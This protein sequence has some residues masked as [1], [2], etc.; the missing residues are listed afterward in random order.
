MVQEGSTAC[1]KALRNEDS[2]GLMRWFGWDVVWVGL[3]W[4]GNVEG[5]TSRGVTILECA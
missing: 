3:F 2:A 4:T 5:W 1:C